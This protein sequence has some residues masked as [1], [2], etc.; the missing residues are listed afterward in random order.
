MPFSNPIQVPTSQLVNIKPPATLDIALLRKDWKAAK[1][2]LLAEQKPT[3]NPQPL[4]EGLAKR[5]DRILIYAWKALAMPPSMALLA[6]G[7]YGRGELF[8]YSDIDVLL[9]I[10]TDPNQTQR[11]QIE[12]FVGALWDIGMELGHSVRTIENCMFEAAHDVTIQT[13]VMEGRYLTG[14]RAAARQLLTQLSTHLDPKQFFRAKVLEMR[15]RH[16]KFQD[17]PYALEPNVKEAPGGLR[18]LHIILWVA[19][20][21]GLGNSF[22]SLS[23]SGIISS[24]EAR[25]LTRNERFL[26]R[27]RIALHAV[28]HR[29][30]DRLVFDLQP[31]LAEYFGFKAKEIGEQPRRAS[32]YLMQA[33]YWAAKAVMQLNRVVLQNIERV[34]FQTEASLPVAITEEFCIQDGRLD[35]S[36]PQVF[37]DRPAAMLDVFWIFGQHA[38]IKEFSAP[39]LRALADSRNQIDTK[40]RQDPANRSRFMDILR[41]NSGV[42]GTFRAMNQ[43]S[44][45]GRYL[46]AFRKIVGQ[47]QHDLFHVYTVDQH[48]LMVLRNLRRF[49]IADHAHEYPFCSALMANFDKPWLLYIAA[50]FH[51]IAKGRGGD[52]SVLGMSDARKFCRNHGLTRNDTSLVVFLVEQHLTLS[53]TAQKQDINDTDV[54]RAFARL[55]KTERRLTALYLLTVADIRGTSPKV[56]NAWK[57]KLLEDLYR[58]TRRVLGGEK[59]DPSA[60]LEARKQEALRI[61]RLYA[62]PET[63]QT[64]FWATL[65]VAF[66]LRNDPQD[67]AWQTRTLATRVGNPE[68]IVRVRLAPVG[69]GLQVMVYVAD[70]PDLFARICGYFDSTGFNIMDARV[71]TTHLPDGSRYALDTFLINDEGRASHYRDI[72]SLLELQLKAKLAQR[73]PLPAPSTGKLSRKSRTFPM[74]PAVDWRTDE[75]GQFG[76]LTLTAADR[77]GLLYTVARLLSNYHVNVHMAKIM[78]LGERVE[79]SFLV[80]GPILSDPKMQLQLEQDL[81][82]SLST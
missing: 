42:T 54:V 12:Q 36:H 9:V 76:L 27:V 28:S 46:P 80:D 43:T 22:A 44:I 1:D 15:Q 37:A 31:P 56:W 24:S 58:A 34:I 21:A 59:I 75:R 63:A 47:M 4:L 13:A 35:I 40:F 66:F 57:G 25:R 17:T 18:D 74:P 3:G 81:L 49:V 52:H 72:M 73:A 29:R 79:D 50:L 7:G 64:A 60:E 53:K 23:R 82:F 32:E 33:Y 67:I 61:L 26:K 6:V 69:E 78:T 48:I 20:A 71:H 10:K 70:Q 51:D 55:V 62:F 77:T 14:S 8:P 5:A 65:D 39:L 11:A 16:L 2:A 30:E 38:E 19:R 41:L 45:L 68:P